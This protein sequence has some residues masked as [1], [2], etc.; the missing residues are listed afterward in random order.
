MAK[1]LVILGFLRGR[2]SPTAE[3]V[4]RNDLNQG[5]HHRMSAQSKMLVVAKRG[6]FDCKRTHKE[7]LDKG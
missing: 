7:R 1:S 6:G 3:R 5:S 2:S 4:T